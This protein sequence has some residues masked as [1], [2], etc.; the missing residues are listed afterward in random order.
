M[1]GIISTPSLTDDRNA[2]KIPWWFRRRVI[3]YAL[4][5]CAAGVVSGAA[6]QYLTIDKEIAKLII[7]NSFI[8]AGAVLASAIGA[9]TWDDK[10]RNQAMVQMHKINTLP[11]NIPPAKPDPTG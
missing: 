10:N 8:L 1:N 5:F 2:G 6:H 7:S 11:S 3:V 9:A 4:L